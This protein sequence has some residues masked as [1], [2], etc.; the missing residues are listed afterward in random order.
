M[1]ETEP[2]SLGIDTIFRKQYE[3]CIGLKDTQLSADLL[4]WHAAE[5]PH[6]SGVRCV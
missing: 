1:E 6:T 5:N 4:A 3:N 2:Q